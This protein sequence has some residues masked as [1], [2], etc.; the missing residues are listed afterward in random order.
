MISASSLFLNPLVLWH[1][2]FFGK[3]RKFLLTPCPWQCL[4]CSV[5][6]LHLKR[7]NL[8]HGR[9]LS[10]SNAWVPTAEQGPPEGSSCSLP[11]G[12]IPQGWSTVPREKFRCSLFPIEH[13]KQHL[14]ILCV[15]PAF[16]CMVWWQ[17]YHLLITAW[18]EF[19][20][21]YQRTDR[22]SENLCSALLQ[23]RC[24]HIW[25]DL[26]QPKSELLQSNEV[27]AEGSC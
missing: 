7:K 21:T 3:I 9:A 4:L 11:P 10:G 5:S 12:T 1:K 2:Q 22:D 17:F 8:H 25:W 20:L 23:G 19:P 14:L 24:K 26:Y 15:C 16:F 6:S 13:F 18:S 27:I